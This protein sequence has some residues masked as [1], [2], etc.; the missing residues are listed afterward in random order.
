MIENL[1]GSVGDIGNKAVRATLHTMYPKEFE[2]YMIS[3]ELTDSSDNILD[4]L[5]FP[6][7][8][9]SIVKSEPYIKTID[10]TLNG[11]TVVRGTG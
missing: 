6:V 3:M 8:P 7:N 4:Y 9:N 1:L 11:V 10:K 5:T 2:L